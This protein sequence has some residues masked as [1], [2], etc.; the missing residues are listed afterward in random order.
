[1]IT[2]AGVAVC[3]HWW[4]ITTMRWSELL[5]AVGDDSLLETGMLL[6]GGVDPKDVM[7]QLSR[8]TASGSLVQLRRGLYAFGGAW[9][10]ARRRP[11]GFEIAN[12]LARGS[13]VSL[14]SVLSEQGII[15]EYV[16]SVTSVTTGRPRVVKTPLGVFVYRHVRPEMFRD[17]EWRDLE[18][19]AGAYVAR[20]EKALIDLLYLAR[21][22]D[23]PAYLRQLRLQNLDRIE[24]DTL[25]E[26]ANKA[27]RLAVVRAVEWVAREAARDS[28]VS[29]E[30]E[31]A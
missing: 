2:W 16:P 21:K 4:H 20:V 19:G 6:V 26:M 9:A 3:C 10:G 7:R 29:Q 27:G 11:H 30:R 5:D 12:R 22:P 14:T 17:Y 8:W 15:P 31:G 18:G 28:A 24:L 25:A 23:D 13:Y 1:M